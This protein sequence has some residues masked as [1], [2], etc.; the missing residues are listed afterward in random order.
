M[1]KELKAWGRTVAFLGAGI[2]VVFFAFY[3]LILICH[4]CYGG[5]DIQRDN[6]HLEAPCIP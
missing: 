1:S 5:S 3:T 6:S 2:V 4:G